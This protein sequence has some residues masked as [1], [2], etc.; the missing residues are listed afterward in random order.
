MQHSSNSPCPHCGEY[1]NRTVVIDALIIRDN[2][3]LLIKRGV[4]PFK[5]YWA[6]PG[7]HVEFDEEVQE[8]VTREVNEETQLM[9]KSIKLFDIYSKPERDPKQKISLVYIVEAIGET[10]AGDDAKACNWYKLDKL[11]EKM[12][13]DHKK[14]VANYIQNCL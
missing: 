10:V 13:F 2:S 8:A 5:N 4:E 1:K 3:V 9:T 6:L 11:P 12:A 14:I 7:G